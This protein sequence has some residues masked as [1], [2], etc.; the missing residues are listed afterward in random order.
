[1]SRFMFL[2]CFILNLFC[3]V[4]TL[5]LDETCYKDGSV[6]NFGILSLN[7]TFCGGPILDYIQTFNN[8]DLDGNGF[9]SYSEFGLG[10]F[11]PFVYKLFCMADTNR[12]EGI[13]KNQD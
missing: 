1:M 13:H 3:K 4:S 10:C 12:K 7:M 9:L 11:E 8:Y 5:G 6:Q 2:L